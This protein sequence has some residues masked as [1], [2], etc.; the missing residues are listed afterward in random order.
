[1]LS[2]RTAERNP[3]RPPGRP[4][5]LFPPER[6]YLRYSA[7][8]EGDRRALETAI[9]P[10]GPFD[11]P[12]AAAHWRPDTVRM[13][14]RAYSRYLSWL[15]RQGFL[16]AEETPAERLT[17]ER[18]TAY[19]QEFRQAQS[20]CSVDQSLRDLRLIM[21]AL[22]PER[23]RRWINKNPLR[24][25]LA[26]VKASKRPKKVFSPVELL[27]HALDLMDDLETEKISTRK[28]ILFRDSLMAALMCLMPLRRKN[29]AEIRIGTTSSLTA[30]SFA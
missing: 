22:A 3:K 10:L 1:M 17:P 13:R 27:G 7:W 29:L 18:L 2:A 26:E 12:P 25:R 8:P 14:C 6:R 21:Q 24:P 30:M 23:D 9:A 11:T 28:C 5:E 16:V 15:R 4:A 20:P 19:L